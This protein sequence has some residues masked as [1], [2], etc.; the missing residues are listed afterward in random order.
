MNLFVG[1]T[2]FPDW[3]NEDTAIY[4][5]NMIKEWLDGIHLDG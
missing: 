3:F 4:W 1:F 2:V 5:E